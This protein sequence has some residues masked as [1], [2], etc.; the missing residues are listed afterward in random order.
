MKDYENIITTI[1][2]KE[3]EKINNLRNIQKW[4]LMCRNKLVNVLEKNGIKVTEWM[5]DALLFNIS[6]LIVIDNKLSY[7][8]IYPESKRVTKILM[9]NSDIII[10][11]FEEIIKYQS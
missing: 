1:L 7:K 5:Y 8:T 4:G 2:K 3:E 10:K 11:H 6:E 9:E